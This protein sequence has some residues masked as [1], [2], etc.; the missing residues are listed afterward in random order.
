MT[1]DRETLAIPSW[2]I[3]DVLDGAYHD[4]EEFPA[5]GLDEAFPAP[6]RLEPHAL[7]GSFEAAG[8]VRGG[9]A[10][11]FE[12]DADPG[13]LLRLGGGSPGV[14]APGLGL[15]IVRIR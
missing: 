7:V 8:D 4:A 5:L 11:Y 15:G 13:Q 12:V 10:A 6:W 9:S 2:N 14:A 1:P 3:R